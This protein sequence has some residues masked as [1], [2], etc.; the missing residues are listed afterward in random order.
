MALKLSITDHEINMFVCSFV[1][2]VYLR[3]LF[4]L[5]RNGITT[6]HKVLQQFIIVYGCSANVLTP[7]CHVTETKKC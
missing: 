3:L 2:D 6:K 4:N 7:M 1:L 5:N